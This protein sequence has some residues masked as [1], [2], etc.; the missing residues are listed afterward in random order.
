MASDPVSEDALAARVVELEAEVRNLRSVLGEGAPHAHHGAVGDARFRETFEKAAVGVAHVGLDGRFLAVNRRLTEILGYS[1][2]ELLRRT[3]QQITHPDDLAPDLALL[4]SITRGEIDR[5][6]MEKRYLKPSGEIV[7]AHL[8]VSCA[9][10]ER[11]LP[12]NYISVI[13]DIGA[14][15]QGEERLRFLMGELAHRSK[16][17]LAVVQSA[18]RR[19]AAEASTVD[20]FLDAVDERIVGIAAAQDLILKHENESVPI[21]ELVARQLA[22]FVRSTDKRVAAEG[23]PLELGPSATHS[24]S[25]ALHELATNAS[26]YGALSRAE[27]RL[28]IEWRAIGGEDGR[29][30]MFWTERGGPR[31]EPP[32]RKGF[33]RRVVEQMVA[34]SLGGDVDLRFEP[35]GLVWRLEAPLKSLGR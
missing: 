11:G 6:E 25:L 19:A 3:F 8:A 33:G 1:E 10:D 12:R 32:Q 31:V 22:T 13:T 15:K 24:L 23:P 14:R 21:A 17:L 26:K 16:N 18:V 2:A 7:W 30:L 20:E 4:D 5:F 35:E 29:F 9:R 34:Q 27:G 28:A